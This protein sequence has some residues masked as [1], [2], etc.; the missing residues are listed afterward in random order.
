MNGGALANNDWQY[1]P[2]CGENLHEGA[3]FCVKCG[4]QL[5]QPSNIITSTTD[6]SSKPY[7][8]W[9]KISTALLVLSIIGPLSCYGFYNQVIIENNSLKEQISYLNSRNAYLE[10]MVSTLSQEKTRIDEWYAFL[11][12][13]TNRRLALGDDVKWFFMGLNG[14]QEL[15][16]N[17]TGG[18]SDKSNWDE[19]WGDIRKIYDWVASNI[20]YLQDPMYPLLPEL[21]EGPI[22]EVPDFWRT[23]GE[24]YTLRHG[25]CED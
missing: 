24:T 20:E 10:P 16:N 3:K 17:I 15:V 23:P 5:I 19:Y 7:G 6:I 14:G 22:Q 9:K 12:S 2:I 8:K 25:D 13:E 4:Y 1:C 18:W 11:R 21:L